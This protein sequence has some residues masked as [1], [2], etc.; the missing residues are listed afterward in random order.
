[1]LVGGVFHAGVEVYGIEWC[2]GFSEGGQTGVAHVAPRTHPQH[3][4]RTT[5]PLGH[6]RLSEE[7][8][9]N[10]LWRMAQGWPGSEYHLLHHNCLNFCNALC[11]ELGVRRIP[12]WVDRVA[13]AASA[14]DTSTRTAMDSIGRTA[15]FVRSMSL[16][17]HETATI[18]GD[19]LGRTIRGE[20]ADENSENLVADTVE[21]VRRESARALEKARA[22]TA[23]LTEAAMNADLSATAQEFSEAA[24]A[25]AQFM[26][27]T[28]RARTQAVGESAQE[29][30]G[31]DMAERAQETAQ[32]LKQSA[33]ETSQAVADKAQEFAD[34]AQQL[35]N[36]DFSV[37]AQ[38]IHGRASEHAQ[39]FSS[40]L[41]S[42]GTGLKKAAASAM[43]VEPS[44]GRMDMDPPPPGYL[45]KPTSEGRPPT[46]P[47]GPPVIAGEED[48]AE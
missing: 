26:Q 29:L 27:E 8:V 46:V 43:G 14:I 24:V 9:R 10:L 34:S 3:S 44:R 4:Y 40:N 20:P 19:D 25:Q 11:T 5:V 37:T 12:G 6:T 2:Y 32:A 23:D 13:R 42:W 18:V 45:N 21:S 38:Q 1:L 22:R 28:V 33:Q 41:W 35:L 36:E 31:E 30:M 48:D 15:E 17:L 47:A 39:A 7:E 16:E